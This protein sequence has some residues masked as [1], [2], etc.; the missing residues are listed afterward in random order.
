MNT[1]SRLCFLTC[2]II[3]VDGWLNIVI[4]LYDMMCD[5]DNVYYAQV[6]ILK[7]D[8]WKIASLLF[9]KY[10]FSLYIYESVWLCVN[11]NKQENLNWTWLPGVLKKTKTW[12]VETDACWNGTTHSACTFWGYIIFQVRKKWLLDKQNEWWEEWAKWKHSAS[13]WSD[14]W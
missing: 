1:L 12:K 3:S 6:R 5:T 2:F 9:F 14:H 8:I 7:W 13:K 4:Y 10:F 11:A